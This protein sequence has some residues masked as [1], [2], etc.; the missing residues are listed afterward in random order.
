MQ[1]DFTVTRAESIHGKFLIFWTTKSA[2]FGE[3]CLISEYDEETNEYTMF[4]KNEGMSKD[5]IKQVLCK[6]V[7]EAVLE[8]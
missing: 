5:F 2:G 1:P 6:I 7:D 4:I 8:D 3:L